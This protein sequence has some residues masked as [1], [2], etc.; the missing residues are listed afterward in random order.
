MIKLPEKE[1]SI[2]LQSTVETKYPKL[3]EDLDVDVAVVGGGMAGLTTA[4]LL[5]QAGLRVV[6]LEKN[7]VGGGVSGHTTGKVTSLHNLIYAHLQDHLGDKTARSYGEANQAGIQL[8][9]KII[10]EEKIDCDWQT[11]DNYVFTEK[12]EE[13]DKLKQEVKVA[14]SL[15][16]P[17]TFVTKT[18]LPFQV[19]GAVRFS[20]Q[21]KMHTRKYLLG[22]SKAIDGDG[23]YVF[24][25]TKVEHVKDGQPATLKTKE[26]NTITAKDIVVATNVPFPLV[27]HVAYSALEYP[28]KSYIVAT[29]IKAE[30]KGMYITPEGPLASILPITIDKERML[31]IGGEGHFPGLGSGS[32]THHQ[33]LANYAKDRF[34]V[35]SIEYRWSAR[36]YLSYDKMPL[37]GKLNPGSKHLYVSTAFMKWGLTN[38]TVA[39]MILRDLITHQQNAWIPVF[40]SMRSSNIAAIPGFVAETVGLH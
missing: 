12:Q 30:V 9:K 18:G 5:K 40:D 19:Q 15:G 13:V 28:L 10:R 4:Y 1:I 38:T 21:G 31:L 27:T 34:N 14:K 8:I 39:A 32:K 11:D 7:V 20:E 17:A 2:W 35:A 33:R 29:R 3:S 16:L 22:L 6:V 36:D 23:S 24:E 37:V 26:G 25:H